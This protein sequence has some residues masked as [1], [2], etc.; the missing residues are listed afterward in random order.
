M[1]S[2][3]AKFDTCGTVLTVIRIA[4]GTLVTVQ[5]YLPIY[6]YIQKYMYTIVILNLPLTVWHYNNNDDDVRHW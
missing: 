4:K 6:I 2:V 3:R 1:F 5:L